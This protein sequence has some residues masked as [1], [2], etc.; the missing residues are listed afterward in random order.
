[1]NLGEM[2]VKLLSD[3][4]HEYLSLRTRHFVNEG[5]AR[6]DKPVTVKGQDGELIDCSIEDGKVVLAF[7]PNEAVKPTEPYFYMQTK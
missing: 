2:I 4:G 7:K 5:D 1:M 6:L 3:A